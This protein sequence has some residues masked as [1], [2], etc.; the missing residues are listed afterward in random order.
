[1]DFFEKYLKETVETIK[2]F[3]NGLITVKRI[4]IAQRVKS[5]DRSKINFIWRAL[6][7]LVD[8]NFLEYN[9]S[10]RPYSYKLKYPDTNI[11]Y[12]EIVDKIS[13]NR[14]KK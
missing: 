6:K 4:R 1:M 10:R 14:K 8:I 7:C 13:K 5:T 3:S 9:D 11:D 12:Y 2:S